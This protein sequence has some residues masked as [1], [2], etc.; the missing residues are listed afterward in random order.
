MKILLVED[1]EYLAQGLMEALTDQHYTVD[2]ATNGQ[3]GWE[4]AGAFPYDLIVMDVMLPRMDGMSICR[5]LRDKNDSTPILLLTAQDTYTSK[6]Q[7]LDAGAD[8]YLVKPFNLSELFARIRALLRRGSTNTS[9]ILEWD[10]LCLDPSSCQVTYAEQ[11]LHLTPKEYALLE[12]FLRNSN[13]I[14]SKSALLDH[15]WSSEKSPLEGTV[16]AHIKSLRKKLRQAGAEADLIETV[17]KLGYRLKPRESNTQD[18]AEQTELNSGCEQSIAQAEN[19]SFPTRETNHSYEQSEVLQL[20]NGYSATEAVESNTH[21]NSKVAVMWDKFKDKYRDRLLI[22]E[23][24]VMAL[25]E[26]TFNEKLGQKALRE[27]H[28]LAGSLGSFGLAEASHLCYEIEQKF[29][30]G[31]VLSTTW[32]RH[33]SKLVREL[34]Q[35]LEQPPKF[36][37]PPAIPEVRRQQPKLLIVDYDLEFSHYLVKEARAWGMQVEMATD[38]SQARKIITRLEPD[39]VL[40]ETDFPGAGEKGFKLLEELA[41]YVPP[42]P[43]LV[44][45]TQDSLTQ[46]VKVA[47]LG[48]KSFLNKQMSP[49]Q[50]MEA[51]ALALKKSSM[52]EA[53][54]FIVDDD[55]QLL[56]LLHRWLEPWGFE[57]TLLNDSQRFWDQLE[58]ST[59]DLLILNVEM[60]DFS[61]IELCQVVRSDPRWNGLPIIFISAHQDTE[62]VNQVFR[63]GADDYVSKPIVEQELI[64]RLL[65]RLERVQLLRQGSKLK[66]L[67]SL[68]DILP[69]Q[70]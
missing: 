63:A 3:L 39:V 4:L 8:D 43:V 42:L 14:F 59:P 44:C 31:S 48:G 55:P 40:L 58:L 57:L 21:I 10:Q 6:V 16:T 69:H 1:D 62:I 41:N 23:Q 17:Y 18:T 61:G 37:A 49:S 7:G 29:K 67:T 20:S 45:T 52:P 64:G 50:V 5:H 22:I 9:P 35:A 56:T 53:K 13:R 34:K 12:L 70:I 54:L 2:L 19:L 27:A 47:R 15:L 26:G 30:S 25:K 46:R 24:A 65:N 36:S 38:I 60:S 68:S 33:L 51:I 32:L 66:E 11:L 28:T